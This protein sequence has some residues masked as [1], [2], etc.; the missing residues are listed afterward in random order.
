M[1]TPGAMEF[2]TYGPNSAAKGMQEAEAYNNS[3]ISNPAAYG[4]VPAPVQPRATSGEATGNAIAAGQ[5]VNSQLPG[6]TGDLATIGQ[7]INADLTGTV[8]PDTMNELQQG[9]AEQG[10][11]TGGATGAA[12]LK[13]L[14]L[15]SLGLEQTGQQDL[16]SILSSLPGAAISQNPEFQVSSGQAY[17][18]G[19][20]NSLWASAPNPS[21][22]AAAGL[23]ATG[24]GF[25][26]GSGSGGAPLP[27]T[28]T[29]NS[30]TGSSGAPNPMSPFT[31]PSPQS[32]T[33]NAPGTPGAYAAW[34]AW[35]GQP[36][37]SNPAQ[38]DY[39]DTGENAPVDDEAY[40]SA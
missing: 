6:Y 37:Y 13:A 9:A 12:Y 2:I 3:F 35:A 38:V 39:N 36:V 29:L 21:A 20:Q 8:S 19:V 25:G 40:A 34:N 33:S 31:T 18:A 5:E 23:A 22:A 4:S 14:G 16:Q 30:L 1:A 11:S 27:P 24:A 28:P 26:V 17:D 7:N 15:T 10:I 32:D